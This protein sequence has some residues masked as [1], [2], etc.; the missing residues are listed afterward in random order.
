MSTQF[1]DDPL[2]VV[3]FAN[4]QQVNNFSSVQG[5]RFL[6]FQDFLETIFRKSAVQQRQSKSNI[7]QSTNLDVVSTSL[8]LI[9]NRPLCPSNGQIQV[10]L[11]NKNTLLLS[12]RHSLH[13][14]R[15]RPLTGRVNLR[16]CYQFK[17][18]NDSFCNKITAQKI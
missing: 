9:K 11:R 14:S 18:L 13:V 5:C 4:N 6:N 7:D 10:F 16:S 15:K 1:M 2:L 8:F 17:L 12:N 3:Y